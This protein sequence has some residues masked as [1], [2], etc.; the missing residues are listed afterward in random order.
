MSIYIS[1]SLVLSQ[2]LDYPLT[3]ARIGYKSIATINNVT[4][5]AGLT[6]YP[7]SSLTNPATFE[8]YRPN[9]STAT[10]TIDAGNSVDVDYL[11]MQQRGV[12]GVTISY[13]SDDVSYTQ[14]YDYNT[15]GLNGA[16]MA[17][18]TKTNA[19]Y[20][21]VVL[22]GSNMA[23][24]AFKIGEALMMSRPI[25]G[26]HSPIN[27]NPV[28]VN[29][30]NISGNGQW[31]GSSLQRKGLQGSFEWNNLKA[32]WY[33]E[34]FHPFVLSNPQS[35]PF[36]IAW[37]PSDYPKEVAYCLTTG[38][39]SPQNTGTIDFMSVGMSVEGYADAS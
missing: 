31:L 35:N 28:Y 19:R 36:F 17:L 4:G 34:N 15:G 24:L 14:V 21:R 26:G 9:A 6:A 37:R 16:D 39:I 3:H 30:P 22:T 1:S 38:D 23:V 2:T 13:S 32:A 27:L 18:F 10:I 20:W 5:T 33:R 29:R 12:S 25:Y 7:L 8:Q 11:A